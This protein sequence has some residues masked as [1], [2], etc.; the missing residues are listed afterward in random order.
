MPNIN[1]GNPGDMFNQI[2]SGLGYLQ[3]DTQVVTPY[4]PIKLH[5]K[6]P[7]VSFY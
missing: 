6:K 1:P 3:G 7:H 5:F 2:F 4:F